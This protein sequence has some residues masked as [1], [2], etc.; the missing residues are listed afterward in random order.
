[1]CTNRCTWDNDLVNQKEEQK[2]LD[3]IEMLIH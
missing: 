1:M 2:A 3:R